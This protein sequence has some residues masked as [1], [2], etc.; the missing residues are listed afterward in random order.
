MEE[1][2]NNYDRINSSSGR[3]NV[4]DVVEVKDEIM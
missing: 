2:K 3:E 1:Q 4:I